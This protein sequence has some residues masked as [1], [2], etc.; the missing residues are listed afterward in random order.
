MNHSVSTSSHSS[1]AGRTR[2][3]GVA[4]LATAAAL[5]ATL[6][7]TPASAQTAA[8]H[9]VKSSASK[10]SS[11][12]KPANLRDP[13]RNVAAAPNYINFCALDGPNSPEC[14]SRALKAINNAHAAEGLKKMILPNNFEQLTMGE[15]TF[16][17]TNL[18]RV[19]RGLRPFVGLTA[20]LNKNAHQAAVEHTDPLL[21]RALLLLLGV[22]EYA[23]IWAGDFG[24]L[25]SDFDWMYNDGYDPA[26][27]VNLDCRKPGASGCWGHRHAIL[28]V[29]RGLPHLLAGVGSVSAGG[30]IAEVLVGATSHVPALTFTWKQALAHGANGHKVTAGA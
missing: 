5:A 18:E 3:F 25:A 16:V 11:S 12:G 26:G 17:V 24:P 23:S 2:L 19:V 21:V 20:R 10:A 22:R 6:S 14:L 30:S 4:S 29:F 28:G 13:K 7:A 1:R 8:F 9:V 27:S 15:Q